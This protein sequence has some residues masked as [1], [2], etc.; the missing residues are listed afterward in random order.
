MGIT[1]KELVAELKSEG[2][3]GSVFG[4]YLVRLTTHREINLDDINQTI[5]ILSKIAQRHFVH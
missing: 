5:S 4:E 2:V 1:A 3:L